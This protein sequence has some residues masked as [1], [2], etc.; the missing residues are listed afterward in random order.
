MDVA[1][2]DRRGFLAGMFAAG[3]A[4]SAS[5]NDGRGETAMP[6]GNGPLKVCV[7]SDLHYHPGRWTNTEDMSFMEKI[8]AR[9]ER[10]RCDMVIHCGDLLHGVR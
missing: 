9:A 6:A 10:E 8:L 5:A 4:A 7:F 1:R 2:I 3:A